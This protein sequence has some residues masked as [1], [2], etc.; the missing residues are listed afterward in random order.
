MGNRT[1]SFLGRMDQQGTHSYS[2]DDLYRLT[3]GTYPGPSTTSYAFDAFG[4]RTSM[5]VAGTRRPTATT[6]TTAS[7]A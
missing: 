3:S 2:H 7:P 4:N 6:T 1:Q 5:T